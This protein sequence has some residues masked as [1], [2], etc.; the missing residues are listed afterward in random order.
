MSID[1]L[2]IEQVAIDT[3]EIDSV[4]Y[5]AD[6]IFYD[7]K[8][9]TIDLVGKAKITYQNSNII[10]DTIRINLAKEQAYAKGKSYLQDGTQNMLGKDIYFDLDSQWGLIK[11]G[12]SECQS[13]IRK[14][15][16]L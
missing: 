7:V 5:W 6:S 3:V 8:N 14:D 10:S 2:Q 13:V 12:I 15:F 4:F 16:S 11:S 9:E 1:S